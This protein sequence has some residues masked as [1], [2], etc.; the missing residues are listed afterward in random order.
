MNDLCKLTR[1]R[2]TFV[3]SH[4][5]PRAL[6]RPSQPGNH[7]IEYGIG[8]RPIK[9]WDSWFD[10]KLVTRRGEDILSEIDDAGIT[11]LRKH[12][13]VWSSRCSEDAVPVPDSFDEASG[14]G[15]RVVTSV[16]VHSLGL[17]FLSLLWRWAASKR[18]EA[19]EISIPIDRLENLRCM[20]AGKRHTPLAAYPFM[21]TQLTE[22]GEP[23]NHAP[24]A[25]T[26]PP[27]TLHGESSRPIPV[28]RFYLDGLVANFIRKPSRTTPPFPFDENTSRMVVMTQKTEK[29]FQMQNM[30]RAIIEANNSWPDVMSKFVRS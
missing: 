23:H 1:T 24:T 3:K 26:M 6:T 7:F 27:V 21:L 16:D 2:G 29:S 18:P 28:F 22:V 10:Y 11:E 4:L 13:L 30:R 19:S 9:R 20:L 8:R 12:H 25:L 5:L 15:I 17:F 14:V